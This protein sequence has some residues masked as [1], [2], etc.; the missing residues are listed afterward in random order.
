MFCAR[1]QSTPSSAHALRHGPQ[2]V[3]AQGAQ[4]HPPLCGPMDCTVHGILHDEGELVITLESWEA[5]RASR[6]VE[7]GLSRSFSGGGVITLAINTIL[8]VWLFIQ[9]AKPL[10]LVF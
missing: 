9:S 5:T 8:R 10:N 2:K 7:E 1:G 3:K 4:S 6:R